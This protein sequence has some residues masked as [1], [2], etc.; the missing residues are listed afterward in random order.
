M[1]KYVVCPAFRFILFQEKRGECPTHLMFVV[2][3]A[4]VFFI[5]ASGVVRIAQTVFSPDKKFYDF[6]LCNDLIANRVISNVS[7][8]IYMCFSFKIKHVFFRL[9]TFHGY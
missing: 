6:L 5:Y 2:S 8:T 4:V 3:K 1:E 7:F 9:Y